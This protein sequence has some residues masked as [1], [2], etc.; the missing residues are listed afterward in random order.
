[1]RIS[2]RGVL[3]GMVIA[4]LAVLP[5]VV[6]SSFALDVLIRILLFAFIGT[7]CNLLGGYAK[8]FSLGHAAFF[9][10]GAYTSTLMQIDLGISPWIGMLAGAVVGML[11]SLPIGWL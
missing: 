5:L 11:G 6:K 10:L 8:Q 9:G 1:M 4:V 7:A 2:R 3:I